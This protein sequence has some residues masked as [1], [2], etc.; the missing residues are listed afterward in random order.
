MNVNSCKATPIGHRACGGPD[1]YIVYSEETTD[2]SRLQQLNSRY[3]DLVIKFEKKNGGSSI[4]SV[5]MPPG[6][7][8]ENGHCVATSNIVF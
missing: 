1:G 2:V 5:E 8:L 7:I 4:C 3:Y 6:V